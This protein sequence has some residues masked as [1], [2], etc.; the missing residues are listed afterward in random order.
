MNRE[1]VLFEYCQMTVNIFFFKSTDN[2]S[3]FVGQLSFGCGNNKTRTIQLKHLTYPLNK[4]ADNRFNE[5]YQGVLI[6]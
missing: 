5:S 4:K 3:L 2:F 6:I 1:G